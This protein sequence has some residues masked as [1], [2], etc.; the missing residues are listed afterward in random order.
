MFTLITIVNG[1]HNTLMLQ[2]VLVESDWLNQMEV[3][4]KRVIS[5]L[6]NEHINSYG[7]FN[8]DLNKR[9]SIKVN[10]SLSRQVA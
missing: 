10:N 4:D 3:E 1:I 8:L 7:S 6:I 2:Q 9:L 5:P